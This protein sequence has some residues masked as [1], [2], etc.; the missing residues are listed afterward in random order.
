[1]SDNALDVL[2]SKFAD[3]K[4]LRVARL[5]RNHIADMR[6]FVGL[7][8]CEE[9]DLSQNKITQIP[10][11]ISHMTSLVTLNLSY[12]GL[13]SLHHAICSVRNYS[14]DSQ[15]FLLLEMHTARPVRLP[16]QIPHFTSA[17]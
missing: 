1:M 4:W 7:T 3:L 8:A 13:A 14:S 15:K 2:P 5:S 17:G 6:P 11:T 12:N 16:S 9:L 10:D